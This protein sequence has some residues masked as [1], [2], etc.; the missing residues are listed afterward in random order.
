MVKKCF[1]LAGV[2]GWIVLYGPSLAQAASLTFAPSTPVVAAGNPVQFERRLPELGDQSAPSLSAF[3]LTL[4]LS[5]SMLG[6]R[7]DGVV[8]EKQL[9]LEAKVTSIQSI[10][11]PPIRDIVNRF[12]VSLLSPQMLNTRQ[13]GAFPLALFTLDALT[14]GI[15]NVISLPTLADALGEAFSARQDT[16]G[17]TVV[18]EPGTFVLLGTFLALG[19]LFAW[20]LRRHGT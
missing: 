7:S 17:V 18:P 12:E 3:D 5:L 1:S 11:V 9:N 15:A 19:R 6:F 2:F 16:N 10:Q 4:Q 8:F 20:R 14:T 13:A